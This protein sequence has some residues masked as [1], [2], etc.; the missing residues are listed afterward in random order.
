VVNVLDC[1]PKSGQPA[2]RQGARGDPR[3]RRPRARREGDQGLRRR[4]RR[5]V[6]QAVTT[7][8]EDQEQLLACYDFPAE[9]WIHLRTTNPIVICS[10]AGYV[11]DVHHE[12]AAA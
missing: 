9:H 10:V 5:Q 8:T 2:A 1:L 7:I 12:A 11:A 3:R 4:L 6:P